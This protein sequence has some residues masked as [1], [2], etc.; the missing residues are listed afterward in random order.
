VIERIAV[1]RYSQVLL[2]VAAELKKVD[3]FEEE[4]KCLDSLLKTNPKLF[5]ILKNPLVQPKRKKELVDKIFSKNINLKLKN[6]LYLLID[7]R[8]VEILEG[9]LTEYQSRAD[10]YR[11]VVKAEVQSA[12]ELSEQKVEEIKK[13]LENK[14]KKTIKIETKVFPKIIGGLIIYIGS[15][16]I[17]RSV[18]GR[19]KVMREKLLA[20]EGI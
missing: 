11:G 7:K 5:L 6:F 10:I 13:M 15:S 19:L 17:D 4:L 12:I 3:E 2:D 9:V 14:I 16:I 8:R 18:T 20:M 1:G